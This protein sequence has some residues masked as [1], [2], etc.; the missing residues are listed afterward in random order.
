MAQEMGSKAGMRCSIAGRWCSGCYVHSDTF[1]F[2][3]EFN[4]GINGDLMDD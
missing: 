4:F 3:V 1:V 2:A